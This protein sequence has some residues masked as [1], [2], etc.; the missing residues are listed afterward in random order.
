MLEQ[1][2]KNWWILALR[3]V[4]A[5]LA[6]VGALIL[7]G[8]ALFALVILFGVYALIDGIFACIA[9]AKA[10]HT[11]ARWKIMLVEGILGILA[12]V[13]A[14]VSPAAVAIAFLMLVAAWAI[15]T[16]ILEI[17][18]AIRLRK[19]IEGEWLLGA[20]GIASVLLG[21]LLVAAPAAGLIAWVLM[22]GVYCIFFGITLL[23]LG[24]KLRGH[25]H[26]SHWRAQTTH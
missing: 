20:A 24:L 5:I 10:Y 2:T 19:E 7:P 26:P 21:V 15:L 9:A 13:I 18:A 25:S 3:G 17:W 8:V 14:L 22:F 16:G 23:A 6:G 12:G 11:N 4:I 1:M